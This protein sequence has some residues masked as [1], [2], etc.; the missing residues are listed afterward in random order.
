MDVY[1]FEGRS[2]HNGE[3]TDVDPN[4]IKRAS[5]SDFERIE[6]TEEDDKK[7]LYIQPDLLAGSDY[8]GTLVERSNHEAFLRDY[9]ELEGII[10]IYGGMGTFGVAIRMDV[11]ENNEEI[12]D[13]MAALDDYCLIDEETHSRMESE[14]HDRAWED[15]ARSDTEAV[16]FGVLNKI[17]EQGDNGILDGDPDDISSELDSDDL[18]AL[19]EECAGIINEYWEIETG[20]NA[21]VRVSKIGDV[22][23]DWF[24]LKHIKPE[25]LPMLMTHEWKT[26]EAR[27]VYEKLLKGEPCDHNEGTFALVYGSEKREEKVSQSVDMSGM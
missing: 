26:E 20:G 15:W 5:C 11:A 1:K 19:F 9:G 18:R 22:M 2:Y 3:W 14:E 16:I 13:V 21:Y 27:Q 8:L 4:T 12:R 23:A 6:V 17:D 7:H 10:D 24:L 25:Y